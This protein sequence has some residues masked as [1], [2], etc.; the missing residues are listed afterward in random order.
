LLLSVA[1]Y[2]LFLSIKSRLVTHLLLT[3]V[4]LAVFMGLI[5]LAV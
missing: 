4:S 1:G 5:W 2:I 3:A